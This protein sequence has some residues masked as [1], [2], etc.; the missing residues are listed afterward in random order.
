MFSVVSNRLKYYRQHA[1]FGDIVRG[2]NTPRTSYL[3]IWL[4][5]FVVRS[6]FQ[7][8]QIV[9]MFCNS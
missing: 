6:L 5:C 9:V 4:M 2:S 7:T 1:C 8:S 3:I